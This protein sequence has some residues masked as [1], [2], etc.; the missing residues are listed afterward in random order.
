MTEELGFQ[1]IAGNR[2]AVDGN[3]GPLGANRQSM[4][5]GGDQL[6]AGA[7]LALDQHGRVGDGHLAD[8]LLHALHGARG[9][10]QLVDGQLLTEAR[11][12]RVDFAA[13]EAALHQSLHEVLELVQ[14]QG[15]GEIVVGPF[16]QRL[17]GRRDR[18]I[19]RHDHDLDRLVV[20]LELLEQLESAHVGHPDVGDG[21]VEHL[22]AHDGE[23]VGRG[24]R[25]GHLIAPRR[26]GF[27]EE[28]QDRV[29]VV[30]DQD[31]SGFHHRR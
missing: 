23:R 14:D 21:G 6:L 2:A 5:G 25:R 7:T 12:Q 31:A 19:A 9:A 20:S 16:L 10:D 18:G 13:Q 8:D 11:P 15:L 4:D 28:Q 29:L 30:D 17:D 22:G 27:L 3:E 26:E 24:V 1:Q